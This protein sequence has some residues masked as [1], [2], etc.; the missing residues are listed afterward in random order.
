MGPAMEKA[1]ICRMIAIFT[2][3]ALCKHSL[4][5]WNVT[6]Q[7]ANRNVSCGPHGNSSN[8]TETVETAKWSGHF[9]KC[10]KD[11]RHYCIHGKCRFVKEQNTP[12]CICP[13]G[14]TGSRCE[15]ID[16]DTQVGDQKQIIIACVIATLVFLI[17][18][19]V[20]IFICAHRKNLCRRKKRKDEKMEEKLNMMSSTR[21]A[22]E[23]LP[24]T[25]ET[26]ETNAV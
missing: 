21:E 17:F 25:V 15:Y 23:S 22:R 5:D 6:L 1:Y 18:L 26:S 10:P 16:F 11:Y 7:P 20:F 13:R 24:A 4:A 12:S 14:Y 8:C 9:T 3:L 19:I 2:V